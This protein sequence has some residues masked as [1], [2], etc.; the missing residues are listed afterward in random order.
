MKTTKREQIFAKRLKEM[1]KKRGITQT[2]L[3]EKCMF[4]N[5][6]VSLMES[7][8]IIPSLGTVNFIA[9]KLD[10]TIYDVLT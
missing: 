3:A 9:K 6:V 4:A 10:C 1:R 8:K 5:P 7:Q 2:E